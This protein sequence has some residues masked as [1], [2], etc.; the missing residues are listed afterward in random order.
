[1]PYQETSREAYEA[2]KPNAGK[3]SAH[4]LAYLE[5]CGPTGSTQDQI[6]QDL[7]LLP[8]TVCPSLLDMENRGLLYRTGDRRKTSSGRSARVWRIAQRTV[9]VPDWT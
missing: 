5:S 1:M 4:I 9:P 3:R 6:S 8:Q 7:G 2:S